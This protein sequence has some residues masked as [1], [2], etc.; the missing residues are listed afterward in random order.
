[1]LRAA[2]P[3]A[4]L[5]V[6]SWMSAPVAQAQSR[7]QIGVLTCNLSGGLGLILT[8]EKGMACT[9]DSQKGYSEHYLGIIRRFG[10]DVGATGGG[11]L[12]W[13][14]F[15]SGPAVPGVLAGNYV[16]ATAEATVGA[17]LGANVLVG[18]SR[19]SISL[20]PLSVNG[21]IG[22]NLALGV[23]SFELSAAP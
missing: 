19:R 22:L 16:G 5:A 4:A 12:T 21:Q 1:M 15:A 20:Q 9:F 7:T 6:A 11:V 10:L 17:G 18:G 13:A 23:G 8:S 14:V 2:L 3:A